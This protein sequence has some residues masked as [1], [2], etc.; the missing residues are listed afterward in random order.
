MAMRPAIVMTAE[1]T[2]A[3]RGRRMNSEEIVTGSPRRLGRGYG[4]RGELRRHHHARPHPLLALD[5]HHV[6][7]LHA[8]L[9]GNHAVAL[10][11]RLDAPLLGLVD[12]ADHE[13]V[14]PG[15]V[16]GDHRERH[17]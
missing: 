9:D 7:W 5:D 1:I 8:F 15:L 6:T 16:V 17:D 4:G 14:R 2:K 12:G 13:E 3:S 10:D 11:A